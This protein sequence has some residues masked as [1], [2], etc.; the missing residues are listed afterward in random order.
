M[1]AP[2]HEHAEAVASEAAKP[3]GA[4][5]K[6][7][8]STIDLT[9]EM[10]RAVRRWCTRAALEADVNTVPMNTLMEVLLQ[11][12]LE[13]EPQSEP[14]RDAELQDRL[15]RAVLRS[16]IRLQGESRDG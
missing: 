12:L 13:G 1:T 5:T 9:H 4:G 14:L 3:T 11:L 16:V 8:R 10:N 2:Q 7:K 15:H 6:K